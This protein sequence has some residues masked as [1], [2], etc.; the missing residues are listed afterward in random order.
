MERVK[1]RE[2]AHVTHFGIETSSARLCTDHIKAV[3]RNKLYIFM[4]FLAMPF[5]IHCVCCV[6]LFP[7]LALASV[8]SFFSLSLLPMYIPLCIIHRCMDPTV[9]WFGFIFFW[10]S[11]AWKQ[12][13]SALRKRSHHSFWDV[14]SFE[15][16]QNLS[17]LL[18][19]LFHSARRFIIVI[20]SR[21]IVSEFSRQQANHRHMRTYCGQANSA[22]I[23]LICMSCCCCHRCHSEIT[24]KQNVNS[25]ALPRES[26]YSFNHFLFDF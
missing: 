2:C 4:G 11:V 17:D 5:V 18:H 23:I 13:K 8:R 15:Q 19:F 10:L 22:W 26:S 12:H 16:K 14:F 24:N 1:E 7:F 21:H 9:K 6:H 25:K 3:Y 20:S